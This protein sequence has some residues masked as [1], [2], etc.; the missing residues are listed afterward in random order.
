MSAIDTRTKTTTRHEWIIPTPA[1]WTDVSLAMTWAANARAAKGL[2][3]EWDDVIKVG[4]DD[5]HIIVFWE[6]EA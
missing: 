5:E 1:C 4:H 2:S 3:N 6:E